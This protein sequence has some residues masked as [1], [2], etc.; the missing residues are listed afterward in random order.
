[1]NMQIKTFMLA[2]LAAL[3]TQTGATARGN[4]RDC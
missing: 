1:M 2:M 3:V 4:S